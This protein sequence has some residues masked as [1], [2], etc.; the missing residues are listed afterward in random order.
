MSKLFQALLSGLF[1][2]FILDFFL[3]LGIKLNYIDKYEIDVYYNILFA[4]NQNIYLFLFFTLIIGYITLYTSVRTA[5]IFVGTLFI[6]TFFT[7]IPSIGE[8]T[9]KAILMQKDTTLHT[10]RF[11]YHGDILYNGRKN[12]TMFEKSLNKVIILPKEKLKG[13]DK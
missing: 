11:S 9:S 13:F 10:E 3:F 8:Y 1:F 12:I 2:T 7:L 4:D 6:L 5:L